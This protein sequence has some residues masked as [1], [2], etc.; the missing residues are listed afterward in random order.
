[1]VIKAGD[2]VTPQGDK[3]EIII[4]IVIDMSSADY[5]TVMWFSDQRGVF[6][7]SEWIRDVD[8]ALLTGRDEVTDRKIAHH[9][10]ARLLKSVV[11]Q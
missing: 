4:G 2:I 7:C 11:V 10:L 5:A 3:N 9:S 6:V 8:P 1:M